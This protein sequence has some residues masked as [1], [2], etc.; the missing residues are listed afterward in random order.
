MTVIDTSQYDTL[1]Q[2]EIDRTLPIAPQVY[3]ALRQRIVDN[4]L[5]PGAP[6]SEAA[7]ARRLDISRTPLRAALQQLAGEGLIVTRPQVGSV[8]AA[9]DT[10]RL[11]EAVFMRSALEE[12]VVRRLAARGMDEEDL[13]PAF[14]AQKR[15][16]DADDYAAFFREDE[17]FHA[18]LAELAGV[19]N[20]WRMVHSVKGHVDRQRYKLMAGIPYR[21][22]RAF[23]D[24]QDIVRHILAGDEEGAA[25]A[26]N[27]HVR[28]VLDLLPA[29]DQ[30]DD[31][32]A[33][34]MQPVA[35]NHAV[36]Q[37]EERQ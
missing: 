22:M 32:T 2:A 1:E 17:L 16:A 29:E 27:A 15:A 25:Q 6:I 4:R 31:G 21:S 28:S 37:G 34:G 8:V 23:Y 24:H 14:A 26:M 30:C 9:L 3:N 35:G 33:A 7:L 20:A 36:S 18:R 13:A 11:E 12:A 19:P 5:G 10:G